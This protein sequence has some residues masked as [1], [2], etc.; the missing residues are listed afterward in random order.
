MVCVHSSADD[1]AKGHQAPLQACSLCWQGERPWACRPAVFWALWGNQGR[2]SHHTGDVRGLETGD[3]AVKAMGVDCQPCRHWI[4]ICIWWRS[5]KHL[6]E[7]CSKL[8]AF[9]A[10]Q[11]GEKLNRGLT[12]DPTS[13]EDLSIKRRLLQWLQAL[14]EEFLQTMNQ[15]SSTIDHLNPNAEILVQHI[16]GYEQS[17]H[18]PLPFPY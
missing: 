16:V 17:F 2:I 5:P 10:G 1:Q 11:R 3:V 4:D 9:L 7:S 18:M 8:E 6:N 13:Q 14:D 15:W 12:P